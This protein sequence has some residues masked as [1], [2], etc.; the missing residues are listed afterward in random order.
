M[1]SGYYVITCENFDSL[2][3]HSHPSPLPHLNAMRNLLLL[4]YTIILLVEFFPSLSLSFTPSSSI[5]ASNEV[6]NILKA[7]KDRRFNSKKLTYLT[8]SVQSL[9]LVKNYNAI[10]SK[11]R[12]DLILLSANKNLPAIFRP[13][14]NE[15]LR[16]NPTAI[17]VSTLIAVLASLNRTKRSNEV[18]RVLSCLLN[19]ATPSKQVPS[20]VSAASLRAIANIEKYQNHSPEL[21]ALLKHAPTTPNPKLF[22]F[23]IFALDSDL[24]SVDAYGFNIVLSSISKQPLPVSHDYAP[25]VSQRDA[26]DATN[27]IKLFGEILVRMEFV[28]VAPTVSERSERALRCEN[29]L[30]LCL[31]RPP[32]PP[33]SARN[34]PSPPAARLSAALGFPLRST[35]HCT[36]APSVNSL[37]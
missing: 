34:P 13:L 5:P 26:T 12:D 31:E 19:S 23:L 6:S 37:N 25:N 32:K 36:Q 10:S 9:E 28:R 27:K 20:C 22:D 8:N 14:I 24:I 35:F 18:L 30:E 7:L 21:A 17:P 2:L 16:R 15:E 1:D 3:P 4:W 29:T 33:F 11:Q